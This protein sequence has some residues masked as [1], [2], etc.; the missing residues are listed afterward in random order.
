MRINLIPAASLTTLLM[1]STLA[2]AQDPSTPPPVKMGLWQNEVTSSVSGAPDT[3]MGRA[4]SGTGRTMVTQGCLTPDTWAKEMQN[5]QRRQQK[6]DCNMTNFVQDTHH[7]TFD[8]TCAGER[9]Y[10]TNMHFEM[11]IDD[12]EHAHG[13]ADVKTSGPAFPQGMTMHMNMKEKFMSSD[14]G[15]VKP[16]EGKVVHE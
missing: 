14:C 13:Q 7:V 12:L 15:D 10:T 8:Q 4:M 1:L 9:G 3:P 16:G 2:L 6:T 5:V 11:L